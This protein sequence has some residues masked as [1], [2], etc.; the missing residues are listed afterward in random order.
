MSTSKSSGH[1]PTS[2][3]VSVELWKFFE[4]RGSKLKES[5][6]MT[7]SWILGFSA[8]VLA[9][10]VKEGFADGKA[11][12]ANPGAMSLL[13]LAGFLLLMHAYFVVK[14]YGE[15]INRTFN[16]ADAAR[17]GETDPEMVWRAGD[18]Y[19]EQSTPQV[20]RY[21]LRTIGLFAAA[22]MLVLGLSLYLY[23]CSGYGLT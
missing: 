23:F 20:C 9:F 4:E 17:K 10:A 18:K 14:D 8:A 12:V 19:K 11:T 15:H 13:V 22:F 2:T 7:V 3:P 21:M 6:F 1:S 16:R 5:M